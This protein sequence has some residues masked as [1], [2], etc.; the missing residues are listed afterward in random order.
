M[1]EYWKREC[2]EA[3]SYNGRVLFGDVIYTGC[4]LDDTAEDA[5]E[6]L[7]YD[8]GHSPSLRDG[9]TCEGILE[10]Y[11]RLTNLTAEQRKVVFHRTKKVISVE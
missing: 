7:V 10:E 4:P 2:L 3:T 1:V 9:R 5:E 11:E 6:R 8:A